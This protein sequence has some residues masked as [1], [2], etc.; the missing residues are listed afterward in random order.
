L[1]QA[2]REW[3]KQRLN[4]DIAWQEFLEGFFHFRR[5]WNL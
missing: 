1:E 5:N 3:S 4:S 2:A